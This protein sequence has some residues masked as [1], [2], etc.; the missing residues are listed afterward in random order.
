MLYSLKPFHDAQITI[1]QSRSRHDGTSKI[2]SI[3]V[4]IAKVDASKFSPT[5]ICPTEVS[6]AEVSPQEICM[7]KLE[8]TNICLT[9]VWIDIW[10]LFP[11]LIPYLH[12][13]PKDI[14]VLL[15]RHTVSLL[16]SLPR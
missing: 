8:T 1:S 14:K 10:V 3:E 16:C 4:G 11:P 12:P 13:L 2:G 6:P 5:E 9:D 15:V 7:P